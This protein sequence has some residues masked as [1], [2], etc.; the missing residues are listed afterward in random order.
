MQRTRDLVF[1]LMDYFNLVGSNDFNPGA[2]SPN[3]YALNDDSL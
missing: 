3:K 2:T 1:L